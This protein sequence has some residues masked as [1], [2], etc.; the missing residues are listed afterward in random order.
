MSFVR[1]VLGIVIVGGLLPAMLSTGIARADVVAIVSAKSAVTTLSTSQVA[2]IFLGNTSR[3]PDGTLAVPIDQPEKALT[4]DEFY[5]HFVGKSPA[6]I[7]A[8]WAKMV[9][10]GRG[11]PPKELANGS[12]VKK[13]VAANPT[14]I[15]YIDDTLVDATVRVLHSP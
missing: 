5:K 3:F 12:E 2:D 10:T 7:K 15:G 11:Q 9:F 14:A 8:H 1:C 4:H 6:Q 13:L